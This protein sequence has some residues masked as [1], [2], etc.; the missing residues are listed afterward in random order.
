MS[1]MFFL[2]QCSSPSSRILEKFG[3][4]IKILSIIISS[5]WPKI[6][7]SCN[8]PLINTRCCR[9]QINHCFTNHFTFTVWISSTYDLTHLI[10][11]GMHATLP[12]KEMIRVQHLNNKPWSKL[13]ICTLKLATFSGIDTKVRYKNYKKRALR[14]S[15]SL[16]QDN[17]QAHKNFLQ[18]RWASGTILG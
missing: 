3:G 8:A 6:A 5:V 12:E 13:Q 1:G 4:K 2:G 9:I 16:H 7:T 15:N 10:K 11:L 18:K 17:A 14:H